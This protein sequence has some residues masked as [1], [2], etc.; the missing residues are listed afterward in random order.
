MAARRVR[1]RGGSPGTS[2][3]LDQVRVLAHPL[4]LRLYELFALAPRTTKQ[5]ALELGQPP[6][7]LYHHVAALERVGLLRLRETRQNRG[8][9]EKYF[10]AATDGLAAAPESAKSTAHASDAARRRRGAAA[11]RP[12]RGARGARRGGAADHAALGALV[13]DRAR[14]EFVRVMG[15][16]APDAGP[17]QSPIL[18]RL[19]VCASA[20]VQARVRREVMAFLRRLG[21][22]GKA[23]PTRPDAPRWAVT[24]ALMPSPAG[25]A[26]LDPAAPATGRRTAA[27]RRPAR[28]TARRPVRAGAG[29]AKVR[30]P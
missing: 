26:A 1:G 10:E 20:S 14:E 9:T 27:Q 8:T 23:L 13:L 5:A 18:A 17:A 30:R 6:T 11:A 21:T 24:L 15:A 22:L 7:R 28:T 16:L 12:G 29:P 3:R 2:P 4:R 25:R 19:V